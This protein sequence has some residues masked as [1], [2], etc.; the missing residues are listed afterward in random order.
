MALDE[1]SEIPST[2]WQCD[3]AGAICA[4]CSQF[5]FRGCVAQPTPLGNTLLYCVTQMFGSD[6]IA[7]GVCLHDHSLCAFYVSSVF[8]LCFLFL[9]SCVL[10][11]LLLAHLAVLCLVAWCLLQSSLSLAY[12]RLPSSSFYDSS[13][14]FTTA[15]VHVSSLCP[16]AIV[17]IKLASAHTL[18]SIF[19]CCYFY[20]KEEMFKCPVFAS[21]YLQ[22]TS[23][24]QGILIHA[25]HYTQN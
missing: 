22:Y 14:N 24:L 25:L 6:G 3:L 21:C 1:P 7:D 13:D 12:H 15:H 4:D 17:A 9:V 16:S 19:Y 18:Y 2:K 5:V 8:S 20:F 11:G 10:W 23:S